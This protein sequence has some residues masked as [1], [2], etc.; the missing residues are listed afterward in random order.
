MLGKGLVCQ[1]WV[2]Q[3]TIL[4]LW[5]LILCKQGCKLALGAIALWV[6]LC[7]TLGVAIIGIAI[8]GRTGLSITPLSITQRIQ[9]IPQSSAAVLLLDWIGLIGLP[10]IDLYRINWLR[11]ILFDTS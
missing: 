6:A 2:P 4:A 1:V 11:L 5:G 8:L 7:T 3:F 9:K 10:A